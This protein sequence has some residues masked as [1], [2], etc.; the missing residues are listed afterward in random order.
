MKRTLPALT[1]SATLIGWFFICSIAPAQAGPLI[2]AIVPIIAG[3]VQGLSLAAIA[4]NVA[5]TVGLSLI[6][7]ALGGSGKSAAAAAAGAAAQNPFGIKSTLQTGGVVSRSFGFGKFCTAGSEVYPARTWGNDGQTPNAY[8]TR[9]IALSDLPMAGLT[10]IIVND[11][12]C[13]YGS[14]SPDASLGYAIPE[15]DIGDVA[16]LWVKFYDG[17]QSAADAWS[18]SQFG[19]DPDYPYGSDQVGAGMAYVIVTALVEQT[20]FSSFPQFQFE[21]LGAAFYDPRGDSSVGGSGAQRWADPS[22]WAH[23]YNPAVIKYNVLRGIYY[24]GQWLFGLQGTD[25]GRLPLDVWFAAMNVDDDAVETAPGVTA[26]QFRCGGECPVTEAPADFLEELN[27]C[28]SGRLAE[29]AGIFRTRSGAATSAVMSFGDGDLIITTGSNFDMFPSLQNTINGISA[30]YHDPIQNWAETDAP[31]L[32]DAGLE[33]EDGGRR[34]VQDF[35]FNFV[36]EQ[37]QVQRLMLAARSEARNFRRHGVV[38]P[39]YAIALDP[40]DIIAWTDSANGYV[41]KLFEVVPTDQADLD[42]AMV[43]L[44]VDPADY[45]WDKDV[46]Y[47]AY[48][49]IAVVSHP[50]PSQPMSGWTVSAKTLAGA[51]GRTHAAI[52]MQWDVAGIDD[53]DGVQYEVRLPSDTP[54]SFVVSGETERFSSGFIYISENVQPE[55]T[56][57]ARGRY[58]ATNRNRDTDWSDWLSVTTPAG[59]IVADDV[60]DAILTFGKFAASIT[61]VQ[62]VGDL[63]EADISTGTAIAFLTTDMKLYR[64]TTADGWTVAVPAADITGTLSDSQ[65]AAIAAAKITGTIGTTQIANNSISTAKL[66]AGSVTTNEIAANTITAADIA[67]ATITGTEIAAGAITA[68][69]IAAGTI[70]STELASDSVVAGKIAAGA[71]NAGT[72]IANNL[73]VTDHLVANNI[74]EVAYTSAGGDCSIN[75]DIDSHTYAVLVVALMVLGTTSVV[76]I[77]VNGSGAFGGIVVPGFTCTLTFVDNRPG[78]NVTYATDGA[79]SGGTSNTAFSL[80]WVMQMKR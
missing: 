64:Y 63:S 1:L 55:T 5:I 17:T 28:D 35:K 39:P 71:I 36:F 9:W 43:L 2:I 23:T 46:D 44:E 74:S 68:A 60:A 15:F 62:V 59:K 70:T 6:S 34:L 51:N 53:V 49:P 72:I 32:F 40:F 14:G 30:T 41:S 73:I 67:A 21:G 54:P 25:A 80:L 42:Q 65:L 20:L 24:V 56:Y 13:T 38:A 57:Q 4:I 37:S 18:V 3:V 78:T 50:P 7:Q 8:M 52:E 22:T 10:A 27:K 66:Q 31:S 69:K 77:D 47:R 26:A 16:H 79:A 61:P 75:L 12:R 19:A 45:D 29:A 11:Q 33:A 76:D 48:T 58:L